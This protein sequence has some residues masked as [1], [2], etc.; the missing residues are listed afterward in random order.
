MTQINTTGLPIIISGIIISLIFAYIAQQRATTDSVNIKSTDKKAKIMMALSCI[1]MWLP[2]ALRYNVGIDN[3]SYLAQFNSITCLS[4]AFTY[5]EPGFGLLCYL[6]KMWFGDYQVLLF[7]SSMLTGIL[8]WLSVY[9]YSKKYV[10]CILGFIAVNMYFMSY[11]VI[12]Q[13]IAVAILSNTVNYIKNR[14]FWKF[15]LLLLCAVTFHYTAIVFGILYFLYSKEKKL[16][17]WKNT[18]II[19]CSGVFLGNF[20]SIV[21]DAFTA[22]S[23]LRDGYAMYEDNDTTKSFKEVTFLLPIVFYTFTFRKSLILQNENNA[24]LVWVVIVLIITKIIGIMTP[25]FSRIHYYFVFAGPI[26]FSYAPIL[27][28]SVSVVLL[29]LILL[30]Y[31]WSISNIFN[32]QWEDFLPY[33]TI[34]EQ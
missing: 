4:D 9:K 28:R 16:F 6:C 26:L 25:V 31:L 7:I 2:S 10:L 15:T 8:M 29:I 3:E 18:L 33:H 22:L 21:G 27:K 32:Y 19:V 12:R 17:T 30:Y 5:Y 24:V 14:K 34:L 1:A 13:F 20:E 11:T 23:T